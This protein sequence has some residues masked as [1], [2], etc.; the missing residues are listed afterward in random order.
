MKSGLF[1]S[2]L[3]ALSLIAT[4]VFA[5]GHASKLSKKPTA[6]RV[7]ASVAFDSYTEEAI[8]AIVNQERA[9]NGLAPVSVDPRLREAARGHSKDMGELNF[10]DH[11]SPVS[12]KAKFTDRIK[13]QGLIKFGSA[14]E[15]IAEGGFSPEERAENFMNM[16]MNSPGHRANILGEDY[17]YIGVGV[18]V[19]EDGEVY[20]TQEFTS[21]GSKSASPANPIE[22]PEYVQP[23]PEYTQ[24]GPQY[25]VEPQPEYTQPDP[26][27][28]PSP[29][30]LF[31]EDEDDSE[32]DYFAPPQ[33]NRPQFNTEKDKIYWL[34]EQLSEP[35]D[36][37]NGVTI[38]ITPA[39]TPK[40]TVYYNAAP[41][42]YYTPQPY[43]TPKPSKK[44]CQ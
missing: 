2:S 13:A 35:G 42:T 20:S 17:R 37:E 39:R 40:P 7:E 25:Y 19:T 9:A 43:Y 8:V 28:T 27:V 30:E 5:K 36:E 29:E 4:P 22:A 15:N 44:H 3:L 41:K 24:P 18:Y 32:D 16:W 23:A 14:G 6:S 33:S 10:F 31:G 38:I 34:L 12:G 11:T 1:A 21:L 26:Y